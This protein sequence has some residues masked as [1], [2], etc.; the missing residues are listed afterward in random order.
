MDIISNFFSQFLQP[1]P[2]TA[3]LVILNL[4]LIEGLLSIDNAAVLAT[5]VLDLPANQRKR[6]L[7]IGLI[8][9]YIFRGTALLFASWLIK[10]AWLKLFGGAYLIYL[11]CQFFY[12]KLFKGQDKNHKPKKQFSIPGFN[13]FW[14]T[15]IMVEVM[16]MT[17]SVDN[18][19][20]AVALTK[21]MAL[22]YLG[23]F[24]G[25]LTMR[26]V[27]GYFVKLMERFPFLDT[28][29]FLIIGMLGLRLCSEFACTFATENLVCVELN[30]ESVDFYFSLLTAGIFFLPV[31]TSLLFNLPRRKAS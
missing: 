26:I 15:V 5:L 10:I 6:A 9:A 27:A 29:A 22:I 28:V 4:I 19:F 18:V 12:R 8:F 11:F 14:S 3:L 24:I 1:D 16:D 7:R 13:Y 23:V 2:K 30:K 25:I 31:L 21:N 20:A 17:F